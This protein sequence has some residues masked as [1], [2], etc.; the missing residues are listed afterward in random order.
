MSSTLETGASEALGKRAVE[1]ARI[2]VFAHVDPEEATEILVTCAGLRC[3]A[4]AKT[5]A[6]FD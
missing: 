4:H 6:C 5:S 3:I 1:N 2:A